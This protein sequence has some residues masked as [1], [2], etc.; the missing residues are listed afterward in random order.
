MSAGQ[1]IKQMR[2]LAAG[3]GIS[4]SELVRRRLQRDAKHYEV[5][6]ENGTLR[7][8]PKAYCKPDIPDDWTP[9]YRTT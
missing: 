3:M 5:V 8:R 6:S 1:T 7:T 2:A 9:V 4:F